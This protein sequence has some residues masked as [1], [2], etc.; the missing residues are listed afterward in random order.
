MK[1]A[2]TREIAIHAFAKVEFP[3]HLFDPAGIL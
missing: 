3:K 2:K 1:F